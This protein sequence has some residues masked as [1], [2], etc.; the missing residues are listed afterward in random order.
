LAT[1]ELVAAAVHRQRE[2]VATLTGRALPAAIALVSVTAYAIN[3]APR[4]SHQAWLFG[5]ASRNIAEQQ[6][7]LGLLLGDSPERDAH[8]LLVGDAG[9]LE[10]FSQMPGVDAF[11]L[12]TTGALPFAKAVRLGNGAT[13]E[14]IE[15]MPEH[16]RPDL[17]ALYPSWWKDLP[18]WFGQRLLE[19]GIAG[20]VMCGASSKVLYRADW[21]SLENH[22]SPATI[23]D[24]WHIVDELDIADV[25]SEA[26]HDFQISRRHSG[27]VYMKVLPGPGDAARERFDAGR[28]LFDGDAMRFRMPRVTAQR[29]LRLVARAAPHAP[30]TCR[31]ELNGRDR[32]HWVFAPKDSWVESFIDLDP[33]SRRGDAE[34]MIQAQR[35]ECNLFHI[36][37]LQ[38]D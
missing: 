38:P 30:M 8:R 2:A 24:H 10:Y 15:R 31:I 13:V 7:R 34:L 37:A 21:S 16:A 17:M 14:L 33:E 19:V 9:A 29:P 1:H 36:W 3:Q 11:G 20:N 23:G 6:V 35:S 22:S 25:V 5:R 27:Y 18:L 32:G 4:V 12:G 28:I 26:A